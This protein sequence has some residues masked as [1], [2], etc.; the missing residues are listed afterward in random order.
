MECQGWSAGRIW[1]A[2]NGTAGAGCGASIFGAMLS[3]CVGMGSSA[4]AVGSMGSS[5]AT[6]VALAFGGSGLV[7]V[8][9]R[10]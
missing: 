3:P 8:G 5:D 2:G 1:I 9:A 6:T 10:K 4:M 7:I